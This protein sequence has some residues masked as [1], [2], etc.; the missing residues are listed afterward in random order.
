MRRM[1][2]TTI[3]CVL[4]SMIAALLLFVSFDTALANDVQPVPGDTFGL[5]TFDAASNLGN[6]DIRVTIARIIQVALS[7]L[8]IVATGLFL[9]AGFTWMT[10]GGDEA[11]ITTAKRTMVNA[12][13]GM[14]IIFTS[15]A[16]VQFVISRLADATGFGNGGG[17]TQITTPFESYSGSGGLGSIIQ[18]HYPATNEKDVPRNAKIV[19]T[20]RE[21]ID[22]TSII[23]NEAPVGDRFGVCRTDEEFSWAED[24]DQLDTA[25]IQVFSV[26]NSFDGELV[27]ETPEG[28]TPIAA[29]VSIAYEP[30]DPETADID[31]SQLARTFVFRPYE[32]LGDSLVTSTYAARITDQVT[33][34]NGSPAF[35]GRYPAPYVWKF[36][37]GTLIDTTP[38]HVV[39]TFPAT[40]GEMARNHIIQVTFSE[41]V[42]PTAVQ[43]TPVHIVVEGAGVTPVGA[44][45]ISNGYRT[46]EYLSDEACGRNSCGEVMYCVPADA[47][48]DMT[49]YEVLLRTAATVAPTSWEARPFTGIADM[50][51]NALDSD[52]LG[53]R[54]VRPPIEDPAVIGDGERVPDNYV[55]SFEVENTID[56]TV[57][58]VRN[59]DPAVDAVQIRGEHTIDLTF[60]QRMALGTVGDELFLLEE[61]TIPAGEQLDPIGYVVRSVNQTADT[62]VEQ[63]VSRLVPN[64]VLG[65]NNLDLFYFAGAGGAVKA[66]NQQCLYPGRG[67]AARDNEDRTLATGDTCTYTTNPDGSVTV[68]GCVLVSPTDPTNDT[69]CAY[70][71]GGADTKTA[72]VESCLETLRGASY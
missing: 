52:P 48:V 32:L 43:G 66:N 44:W 59:I 23:L 57:P 53:E 18:D 69:G 5:E 17:N 63:T 45:T 46:I 26:P 6:R 31:E 11:K 1:R 4:C 34:A 56:T 61:G 27:R 54:N 41:P 2:Q 19:V 51:G 50:A 65:P 29:A 72:D 71:G 36:E 16:I 37:V 22:P 15:I 55:W 28:S 39:D 7:L 64:R 14:A 67:P 60:S 47:A 35:G 12:V 68:A 20:F 62:G 38:P 70:S 21:P 9:Y 58:Y 49:P 3:A 40:D 25:A 24:C 8:G 42:D 30:D 33:Q 10:S 13:I